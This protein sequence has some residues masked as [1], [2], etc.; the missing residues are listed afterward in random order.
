MAKMFSLSDSE[1][2]I[3]DDVI[4]DG[5]SSGREVRNA[6][7]VKQS[8]TM[9]SIKMS[10]VEGRIRGVSES[11]ASEA[12]M[13]DELTSFRNR[14]HSAPPALWAARRYGRELRRMSDE[15]GIS[16][17]EFKRAKSAGT[18]KQM[19]T[20]TSWWTFLWSKRQ[21]SESSKAN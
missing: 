8:R 17:G 9:P 14:S 12:E 19:T 15:F 6:S 4:Q 10:D 16:H 7:S 20:S 11:Q 13:D 1:S 3:S 2:D 21:Q 5:D 18:A